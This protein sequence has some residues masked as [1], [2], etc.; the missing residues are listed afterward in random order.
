MANK[1]VYWW[2]RTDKSVAEIINKNCRT[3]RQADCL[4]TNN[5][6]IVSETQKIANDIVAA[7]DK[8]QLIARAEN[9]KG[10]DFYIKAMERIVKQCADKVK[11]NFT[12][13]QK[14]SPIYIWINK[15]SQ[16]ID[17]KNKHPSRFQDLNKLNRNDPN[18]LF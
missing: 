14:T 17:E 3:H 5:Y 13:M 10:D 15:D 6:R 18:F 4:M 2:N 11:S 8:D 12:V 1:F 7:R 16:W 9:I